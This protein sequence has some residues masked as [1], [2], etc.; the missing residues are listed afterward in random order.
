MAYG[1]MGSYG[2]FGSSIY[3]VLYF[4]IATF[5]FSAIFW[6]THNWLV[7]QPKKKRK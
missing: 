7:Q 2:G 5:I 1:M 4:A 6:L 3:K